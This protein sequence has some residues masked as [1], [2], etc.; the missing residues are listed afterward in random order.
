MEVTFFPNQ[1]HIRPEADGW[2]TKQNKS[3]AHFILYHQ[4]WF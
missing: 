1:E 3:R 4:M 2:K